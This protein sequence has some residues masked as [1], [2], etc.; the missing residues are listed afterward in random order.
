MTDAAP[1]NS[2]ASSRARTRAIR[3]RMAEADEPV[4]AVVAFS[5]RCP[6]QHPK[7][8]RLGLRCRSPPDAHRV[9]VNVDSSNAL[10][11]GAATAHVG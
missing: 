3:A 5:T 10:N 6:G 9:V 8:Q 2:N 7:S 4:R 11:S 1:S